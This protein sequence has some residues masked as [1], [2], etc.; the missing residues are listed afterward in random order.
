MIFWLSSVSESVRISA[1]RLGQPNF[2]LRIVTGDESYIYGFDPE[3][4]QQSSPRKSSQSEEGAPGQECTLSACWCISLTYARLCTV[5]G[6]PRVRLLMK[7]TTEMFWGL[8]GENISHKQ[9]QLWWQLGSPT[10][11]CTVSLLQQHSCCSPQPLFD[12]F[13]SLWSLCS[14]KWSF[15]VAVDPSFRSMEKSLK[16]TQQWSQKPVQLRHRWWS[17]VVTRHTDSL[18]LLLT[19]ATWT[20]LCSALFC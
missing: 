12:R 6:S 16:H 13:C 1:N 8:W 14:P 11:P 17:S 5:Y 3:T 18:K 10:W 7:S 4:K 20:L 15:V 2:L 19:P 9:P